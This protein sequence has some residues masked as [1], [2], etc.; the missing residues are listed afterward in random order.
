MQ[1]LDDLTAEM[2]WIRRLAHALVNDAATADDVAQDAW[3]AAAGK[4]PED[5]PLRPWLARVVLNVVRMR[6]RSASRRTSYERQVAAGEAVEGADAIIARVETQRLVAGE[7]LALAEPYRSTLLLHYFEGLSS[8][9]IGR[10]SGIPDGTVRRR[11]KEARSQLRA[12]LARTGGDDRKAWIAP[13]AA[14]ADHSGVG[15]AGGVLLVKKLAIVALI[16]AL[17]ATVLLVVFARDRG[18]GAAVPT[19]PLAQHPDRSLRA[20]GVPAWLVQPDAAA[21]ALGGTVLFGGVPVAG[22]AVALRVRAQPDVAIADL[23]TGPDGRFS[24]G[25]VASAAYA[26]TASAPGRSPAIVEVQLDDPRAHPEALVLVLG[27]C[28]WRAS[29]TVGDA[30]GTPIPRATVRIAALVGVETD[31]RGYYELCR[32]PGTS[33]VTVAAAGYGGVTAELAIPGPIVRDFT[34][35][36]E[37]ILVGRVVR[38][39]SDVA[40]PEA[41][42]VVV[43]A[44]NPVS[45]VS[46]AHALPTSSAVS[47]GEGRFQIGGLAMGRFRVVA[48]A[49]G[50]GSALVDLHL[51]AGTSSEL[52]IAMEARARVRGR[53]MANGA[54]VAGAP[55][56]AV[57]PYHLA[58]GVPVWS[59][60]D[61]SFVVD[62]LPY[63]ATT[64]EVGGFEVVTPR[65]TAIDRA[66]VAGVVLE[67]SPAAAIH[68]RV[69]MHGAPVE[70][71]DVECNRVDWEKGFRRIVQTTRSDADG[72]FAIPNAAPGR[73]LLLAKSPTLGASS[74][75][76]RI[77]VPAG[78]VTHADAELTVAASISGNVLDEHGAP[79]AAAYVRVEAEGDGGEAMSDAAGAFTIRALRGG[80]D[81]Q[82][83]VSPSPIEAPA[84]ASASGGE[85]AVI[86]VPDAHTTVTGVK[87]VIRHVRGRIR[88]RVVDDRGAPIPDA[89]VEISTGVFPEN[90]SPLG[91]VVLSMLPTSFLPNPGIL[92]AGPS[93]MTDVAGRFELHDLVVGRYDVIAYGADGSSVTGRDIATGTEAATLTIAR[94]GAIE[95]T[96]VGFSATPSIFATDH[97]Y[98]E[99][100]AIPDGPRFAFRGLSPGT[101]TVSARDSGGAESRA[102]E[103]H[104]GATARVE[105]RSRGSGRIEGRVIELGTGAA[106]VGLRCVAAPAASGFGQW[107][108]GD[109]ESHT[110]AT[111]RFS[112]SPAPAG[113][114]HVE[115]W[116]AA[117]SRAQ[118]EVIVAS[119]AGAT[120]VELVSVRTSDHPS[121]PG[122][123]MYNEQLPP[124]VAGIDPHGAAAE[125]GI[126]VGDQISTIDGISVEPFGVGGLATLLGRHPAGSVAALVIVRG[127]SRR[128]VALTL[129]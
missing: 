9:E 14:L 115:C 129:R 69:T 124:T 98:N 56:T 91:P 1:T 34:L 50:L 23:V 40:V 38:A 106:V 122:F 99:Q 5:R 48:S 117:W 116:G 63:G 100:I 104:A 24:F 73:C 27:D 26:V 18:D 88:G 87:L 21:R 102:V 28:A 112:I 120:S 20:S 22:A 101:Y 67:V 3:L 43:P 44:A 107:W 82:P 7:V 72:A 83:R 47:D 25:V 37:A 125:A 94:A 78:V 93:A 84:F 64:W 97:V 75:E 114:V 96:L 60:A 58:G 11:L 45:R 66:E 121:N 49:P 68:G 128:T 46:E 33:L 39:G 13:V 10:R 51:E 89:R 119:G 52:V 62:G 103:V 110:D 61:G 36:P 79:I 81:Y 111:G 65:A 95:G 70:G 126:I 77:E 105:L 53:V 41:Q 113:G 74:E 2:A 54:P 8:A 109:V 12:R 29:G 19:G 59:R 35:V 55:V 16:I 31:A 118:R 108:N 85:L 90:A 92:S 76:R 42:V 57:G 32:P 15:G 30:A 127:S 4:A 17:I 86:H 6:A 80:A 71:A 123:S